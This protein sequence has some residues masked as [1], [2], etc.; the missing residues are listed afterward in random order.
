[1]KV[2]QN[3]VFK[4][5]FEGRDPMRIQWYR[6]GEELLDD[7][8]VK[9]EKSSTHSRL[10]LSKCQRKETGEIKIRLRNEFGTV[11]AFSKLIVLGE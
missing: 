10:L 7:T 4:L 9:I 1:M 11:E 2:G 3:A 5:P 6:E 8:N